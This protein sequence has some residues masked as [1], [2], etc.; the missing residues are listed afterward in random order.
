M[1]Y[2]EEKDPD[3][4]LYDRLIELSAKWEEEGNCYGYVKNTQEEFEGKRIFTAR[5]EDTVIAY[6]FGEEYRSSRMTS[7]I[8]EGSP[9]F[10]IDEIYVLP[11]YRGKGIGKKLFETMESCLK[12][13]EAITLT[14]VAGDAEKLLAFYT[15]DNG[16]QIYSTRLFKKTG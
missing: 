12:D 15:G 9:C 4:D 1:I 2:R 16:M 11:A 7:M 8:K 10:E 13:C 5:E 14:A 6:L 3:Q